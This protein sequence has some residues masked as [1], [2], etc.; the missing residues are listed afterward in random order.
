MPSAQAL[1]SDPG[2]QHMHHASACG[3]I[4]SSAHHFAI[5]GDVLAAQVRAPVA[6]DFDESGGPQCHEQ[7][8]E[9]VV[10]GRAVFERQKGAQPGPLGLREDLHVGKAIVV[11]EHAAQ[12]DP[13]HLVEALHGA[14]LGLGIGQLCEALPELF[15]G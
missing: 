8:T 5:N 10:R 1:R 9:D 7:V 15:E 4:A 11:R 13:E 12:G 6:N 2:A 3:A 14:A